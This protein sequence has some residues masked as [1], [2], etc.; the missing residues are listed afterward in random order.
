MKKLNIK[1]TLVM[2]SLFI[3]AILL[4]LGSALKNDYCLCFGLIFA[5]I[6]MMVYSYK[7]FARLKQQE[8][9]LLQQTQDDYDVADNTI[10]EISLKLKAL[11][12][13][14]KQLIWGGF[15]FSI[16][17]IVLGIACVL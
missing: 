5:S 2:V 7:Q 16:L 12:K 13:Q 1:L 14:R 6:A 9:E 15:A 4:I 8:A 17:L 10:V 11:K 3:S